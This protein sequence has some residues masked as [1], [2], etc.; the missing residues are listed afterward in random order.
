MV[1]DLGV[2]A[3]ADVRLVGSSGISWAVGLEGGGGSLLVPGTRVVSVPMGRVILS[4]L[5]TSRSVC[6][7]GVDDVDDVEVVPG[8]A[9]LV[10]EGVEGGVMPGDGVVGGAGVAV[11]G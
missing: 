6:S 5:A 10:G 3:R 9:V 11:G 8:D 2:G 1:E 4:V 7:K